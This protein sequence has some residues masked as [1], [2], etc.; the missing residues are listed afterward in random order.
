MR[1]W[2]TPST[3]NRL[4]AATPRSRGRR[5]ERGNHR[6]GGRVDASWRRQRWNLGLGQWRSSHIGSWATQDHHGHWAMPHRWREAQEQEL[7]GVERG[8]AVES[9]VGAGALARW[10]RNLGQK[11]HKGTWIRPAKGI[12]KWPSQSSANQRWAG[13]G[14]HLGVGVKTAKGVDI[15]GHCLPLI[16]RGV[17]EGQGGSHGSATDAGVEPNWWT[18]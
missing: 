9:A 12:S 6:W 3:P 7:I 4:Q 13:G 8:S 16:S 15:S 18:L 5:S 1:C 17:R 10:S 14:A 11:E 2:P